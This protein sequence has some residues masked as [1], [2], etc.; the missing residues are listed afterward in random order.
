ME[1][2]SIHHIEKEQVRDLHFSKEKVTLNPKELK[3]I[4]NLMYMGMVLGNSYRHKVKIIFNSEE[5]KQQV[6]T[7]IWATT[8]DRIV[9]KGGTIIPKS[10][11]INIEL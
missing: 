1:N 7:T 2:L 4:D 6:E 8:D 5:G 10:A 11:I 9:L 3:R